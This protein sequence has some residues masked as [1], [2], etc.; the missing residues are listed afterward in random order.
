M[1][2][3]R[4]TGWC[5]EC[6]DRTPYHGNTCDR[7][8]RRRHKKMK[9][10][11]VCEKERIHSHGACIPCR[12]RGYKEEAK[13]AGLVADGKTLITSTAWMDA[14]A[15]KDSPTNLFF[16]SEGSTGAPTMSQVDRA[17]AVCQTCTV[18][19]QCGE[20]GRQTVSVG[21]WGGK[22]RRWKVAN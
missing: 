8:Y 12:R 18:V 15:C 9:Y 14:A 7:C 21:I 17:I 6:G 2:S 5:D 10:C 19:D 20:F 4:R 3:V 16:P 22:W 11:A 1:P 13:A